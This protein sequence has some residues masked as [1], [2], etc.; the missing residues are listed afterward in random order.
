[1]MFTIRPRRRRRRLLP[2]AAVLII[3]LGA[4]LA[5]ARSGRL[6]AP[7]NP[8]VKAAPSARPSSGA[9]PKGQDQAS[10]PDVSLAGLRWSDF[11]GVELPS[12]VSAGPREV[13]GG[14][15][16]GFAH[17]PLG[18]LLAAVNIGVRANAQWGPR[19]FTAVIRGQITGPDAAALLAS[20]QA[21]YGQASQSEG[22]TAGQPL[23]N[24]DVAEEAF[25]W[26]AYTPAAAILD[27][28]SAAPGSNG[29]TARASVQMEAVWDGGD[30]KVVAPPGGDWGNSAAGLS[31]LAGY[32][33]FPAQRGG[34]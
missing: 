12:S 9:A 8:A 5:L 33:V 31:S 7:G 15:A 25:R 11:Y 6:P 24:A 30:W 17:S 23:G 2:A 1:M 13:R 16:A 21:A 32:T 10:V 4:G 19:I 22:V 14:V 27:L 20:C 26:V 28:V 29:A 3:I 18:A 34:R